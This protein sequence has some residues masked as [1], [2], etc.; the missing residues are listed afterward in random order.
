MH[1]RKTILKASEIMG[2][3]SAKLAGYR[4]ALSLC[5]SVAAP[6]VAQI[7]I[8]AQRIATQLDVVAIQLA[9]AQRDAS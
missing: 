7:V 5:A 2:A 4:T 6:A 8:E 3:A 1:D 9:Q